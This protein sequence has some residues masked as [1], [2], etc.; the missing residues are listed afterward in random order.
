MFC[1]ANMFSAK[2]DTKHKPS[3]SMVDYRRFS[4]S[5]LQTFHLHISQ[6][7]TTLK[8]ADSGP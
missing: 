4:G 1:A 6:G 3:K 7:L 8:I 2:C 5:V